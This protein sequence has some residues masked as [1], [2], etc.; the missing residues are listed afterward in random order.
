MTAEEVS[1]KSGLSRRGR[2]VDQGRGMT[3]PTLTDSGR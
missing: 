3:V 1:L 2:Q